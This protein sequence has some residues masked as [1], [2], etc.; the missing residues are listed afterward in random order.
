MVFISSI[1]A[2]IV[3]SHHDACHDELTTAINDS[4]MIHSNHEA[5]IVAMD[6]E[7][8]RSGIFSS[9]VSNG[10][11]INVIAES[12]FSWEAF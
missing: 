4:C 5:G 1:N 12:G 3:N 8:V 10:M 9:M 7:F 11:P 6:D 2:V